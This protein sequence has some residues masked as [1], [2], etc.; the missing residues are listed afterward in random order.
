[1]M[2]TRRWRCCCCEHKDHVDEELMMMMM[3]NVEFQDDQVSNQGTW[4]PVD[5]GPC[6][7][8]TRW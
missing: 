5:L 8:V 1:M 2:P 7:L 6:Y 3:L 4:C